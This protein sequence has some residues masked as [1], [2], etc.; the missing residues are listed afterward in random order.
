YNTTRQYVM[1]RINAQAD[2]ALEKVLKGLDRYLAGNGM[3]EDTIDQIIDL[4]NHGAGIQRINRFQHEGSNILH[5]LAWMQPN[6]CTMSKRI[7]L[8]KFLVQHP[9]F[10]LN[11]FNK[12]NVME[13]TPLR[14][15][16]LGHDLSNEKQLFC[17]F[18]QH[19]N[20]NFQTPKSK[21]TILHTTA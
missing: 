7:G 5:Y 10:D 8:A 15:V 11:L 13:E 16:L 17:F 12:A 18:L 1:L 4:L 2:Q 20:I 19:S 3:K 6:Q 21:L 9:G 14:K